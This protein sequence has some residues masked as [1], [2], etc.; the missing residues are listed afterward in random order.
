MRQFVCSRLARQILSW[1]AISLAGY[2]S[3]AY[4]TANMHALLR[5]GDIEAA[6]DIA[7]QQDSQQR[8]VLA[9]LNKGTIRHMHAI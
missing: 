3:Y 6:S 8:E 9:S 7:E 4:R 2:S 5:A 1:L